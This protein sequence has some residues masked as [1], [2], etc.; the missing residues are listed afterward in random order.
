MQLG[1]ITPV[2]LTFNEEPNIAR[3]LDKLSWAT[4]IIVV[5]SFSSDRTKAICQSNPRVIWHERAFDAHATQW[6]FAVHETGIRTAWV[7]ALDAD[8]ILTDAFTEELATLSPLAAH[9]GYRAAFTYCVFGHGL[10]ASLYPPT[11]VLFRRTSGCYRQ[12]GHTQRVAIDGDVVDMSS[13]IHHD[14]R[15][16]L[17]HWFLSQRRY[18]QLE[19]EHLLASPQ[20]A[21][22]SSDRIRRMGWPAPPLVFVYTLLVKGA[23]FDGWPGWFYVLQRTLAEVM[24]ALE[25]VERRLKARLS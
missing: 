5:D 18:A 20:P 17:S 10:R 23:V 3:C 8:Y 12:F 25:I 13:R 22:R 2:I 24:I 14:D 4:T 9:S 19:A 6:N 1:D 16:P 11:T 15:K 7:L 21:L